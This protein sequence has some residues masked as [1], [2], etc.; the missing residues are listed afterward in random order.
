MPLSSIRRAL[1]RPHAAASLLVWVSGIALAQISGNGP[2]RF[3]DI[4]E[5]NEHDEQIDINVQFNCSVRYVTHLPASE[6]KELRVQLQPLPD[7][8]VAPGVPISGEIPPLSGGAGVLGAVRV[9]TD[10]PGQITLVFDFKKS[11]QFVLAQGVDPRALR[12]RVIR[13]ISRK[14]Q[15]L[16]TQPTDSVSNFAINLESQPKPFDPEAVERAHQL[17]Q[18]PAF[19]SEV[20]MEGQKWY[21]LRVGPIERRSEADHLLE[22]AL[23]EY[24]R[25]WLAIGDDAVT[26]D[27]TATGTTGLPSVERMGSD[28]TLDPATLKTMLSQ[29]KSAMAAHDYPTAIRILTKL[30]RQP[31]FPERSRAQELLGL[32][33]ERSGQLAHAKAEYEEYLR[34]YPKGEAAERVALRLRILRAATETAQGGAQPGKSEGRWQFTGGVAQLFRYDGTRVDNTNGNAAPGTTITP[35]TT[36]TTS[37]NE[38]FNNVDLLARR[39]GDQIDWMGRLSTGYAKSFA[40]QNS[41]GSQNQTQVSI[42]SVEFVDRSLGLLGRFGRQTR[43]QDGVLGTFDGM[44]VSYQWRPAWGINFTTGYPVEQTY[45]SV[46]S[47]RRFEAVALAYSPPGAHWDASLFAALEQFDGIRDRQATGFEARYLASHG[48]L[49]LVVDYDTF[50]RSLNTA[51]LLG[52]VQLPYRWNVSFD[53][54]RRNSPVLTTRNALIGQPATTLTQLESQGFS[55]ETLFQWA[56][57]RTPYTTDYSVTATRP[58]GQRLQFSATVGASQTSAT[59]GSGGVDAQPPT[60]TEVV[61]Q[62]QLYGSSLWRSGDFSVASISYANT[63]TGKVDTASITTRFPIAGAWRLGPRLTVDRRVLATDGST[64]I[65]YIPAALVDY[66]R[67]LK[68]LQFEVGGELGKRAAALETQSTK[69]YY[70]SLS[71]RIGF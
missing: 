69:R 24:P 47:D 35:T 33:R 53:A 15:I 34:R 65:T 44:F 4:V 61:Y 12:V 41:F 31:E 21:R 40:S 32:A 22:K 36:Q 45:A 6:G 58:V 56:R 2:G 11:E 46:R 50:Y 30:Q 13:P 39:R 3:V 52:T 37:D 49:V 48:S 26:S 51:S 60:G 66:Q 25:A 38:L 70:V 67:G 5:V 19:V 57:D 16:L 17:L 14:G 71:Y 29:V 9:D 54:E 43:N 62:A 10:V 8:R 59:P 18:A 68:L 55:Q 63:Q 28:P 42:A 27:P 7:C 1:T 20:V 23:A 64:E